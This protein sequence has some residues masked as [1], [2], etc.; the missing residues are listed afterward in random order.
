MA[1]K[2]LKKIKENS[3][4]L[5]LLWTSDEAHFHLDGKANS[6]TNV[7]WGFSRPNAVVTKPLHSPK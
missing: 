4:F 3:S 2:T 6:R 5:N 7:F 1:V